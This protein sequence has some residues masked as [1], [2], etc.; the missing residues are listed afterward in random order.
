[1]NVSEPHGVSDVAR[2]F[3]VLRPTSM[4]A[5][6]NESGPMDEGAKCRLMMLPKK[7]YPTSP[8]ERDMGFVEKAGV[9]MKQLQESFLAGE[10]YE[11]ETRGERTVPEAKPYAEGVYAI[12]RTKR[13][14]HLA[15]VLTI[16]GELGQVQEDFGLYSRGSFI[17]Q[18]KNPKFPGP[19]F[20]QLP[21]DPEY[22]E[23]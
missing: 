21:K 5:V 12:T 2:S 23:R 11:T 19:S 10:T 7:K 14:S 4:G 16:P 9:S 6:F 22:P 8:K 1:M 13:A 15:Y 3:F 17:M 20:A 18:A